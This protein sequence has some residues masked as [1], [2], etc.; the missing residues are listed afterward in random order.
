MSRFSRLG[1]MRDLNRSSYEPKKEEPP[2]KKIE[3]PV[4]AGSFE[5]VSFD[6]FLT[7]VLL[8]SNEEIPKDKSQLD[9]EFT[10]Q[11]KQVYDGIILPH[12][13]SKNSP[14]YNIYFPFGDTSLVPNQ[15][16]V[17]PTGIKVNLNEGWVLQY[18]VNKL[19][20]IANDIYLQEI[21]GY[22]TTDEYSVLDENM[23]MFKIIN[24][25][26]DGVECNIAKNTRLFT[27]IF[28]PYGLAENDLIERKNKQES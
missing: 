16:L 8:L 20:S 5:K 26:K 24:K 2:I 12:R 21:Y 7:S 9:E 18:S 25:N 23:L 17:I 28:L 22:V 4:S 10:N 19:L 3:K 14:Y 27:C 11:I 1:N 6:T 13:V 15:S